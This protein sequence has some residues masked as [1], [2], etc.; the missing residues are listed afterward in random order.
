MLETTRGIVFHHIRY[1]DSS[2]IAK[3]YTEQFG[4]QSYLVRG[5][6]NRRS[7]TK[8]ALFQHLNLLDMVVSHR[9]N[10]EL[11]HLKEI[12]ISYPFNTIPFDIRKSAIALFL[13]EVLY[14]V[15]REEEPN[16]GLFE[17]LFDSIIILDHPDLHIASFHLIFLMQ[18][19]RFLGFFPKN[20]YSP[21]E[22]FFDLAEG[23]FTNVKG[24]ADLIAGEPFSGYV[25]V[26]TNFEG[27]YQGGVHINQS[28]RPEL[29]K[30]IL[31]YYK[32]HIPG[33]REFKSHTVLHEVLH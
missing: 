12:H 21:S 17:F 27:D 2:I 30:I 28:H 1:S 8:K 20:N 19:S 26:L 24:P 31:N 7:D 23:R 3:I 10:K 4:L 15:I 18:L 13:N 22:S 9:G 14:Q 16:Q 32:H 33:I 6:R 25:S 29:L 5:L 11:Q